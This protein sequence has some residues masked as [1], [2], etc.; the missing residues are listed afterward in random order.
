MADKADPKGDAKAIID[1][2]V[3]DTTKTKVTDARGHLLAWWVPV[4]AG[5]ERSF[6]GYD[7]VARRSRTQDGREITE[8]LVLNDIYNVTG[9]Y[10]TSARP[11]QDR[12][13]RPCIRFNLNPAG[14]KLVGELTAHHLPDKLKEFTYKL[15]IILNGELYSAPAIQSMIYQEGE[16]TGSFSQQEVED[17]SPS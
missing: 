11:D 5:T 15:G 3:A 10:I 1:R 16:I 17:L 14:G 8:L 13:R 6:A 2:A 9:A 7:G 4:K 12:R